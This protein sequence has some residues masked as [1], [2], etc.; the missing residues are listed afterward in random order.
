MRLFLTAPVTALAI[1]LSTGALLGCAA[2]ERTSADTSGQDATPSTP[3]PPAEFEPDVPLSRCTDLLAQKWSAGEF[4]DFD[5]SRDPESGLAVF[6]FNEHR[7]KV[8]IR[9]DPDCVEVP[10][11]GTIIGRLAAEVN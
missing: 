7:I 6:T 5:V 3:L 8:D 1:A 9:H 2:D 4:N 11:L 10:D